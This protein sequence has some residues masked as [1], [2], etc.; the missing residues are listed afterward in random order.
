MIYIRA[1]IEPNSVLKIYT[2]PLVTCIDRYECS[3]AEKW[4]DVVYLMHP[5]DHGR[6]S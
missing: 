5:K 2:L 3:I 1:C 6:V 4:L